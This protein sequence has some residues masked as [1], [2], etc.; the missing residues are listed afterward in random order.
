M[1][2][3]SV[4]LMLL[5]LYGF[6]FSAFSRPHIQVPRLTS[7]PTAILL[8][9][10]SFAKLSGPK[11]KSNHSANE[12]IFQPQRFLNRLALRF[13]EALDLSYTE[14]FC[15][16]FWCVSICF[17]GLGIMIFSWQGI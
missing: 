17:A 8:M 5:G 3:F 16:V 13:H 7:V 14:K 9:F 6:G 4:L 12:E 10:W 1:V 11:P 2:L 15:V